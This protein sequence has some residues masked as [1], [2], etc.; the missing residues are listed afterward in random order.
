MVR[1]ETM[2]RENERV[3]G[4]GEPRRGE[5]R[6]MM[7]MKKMGR[8]KWRMIR[9]GGRGE[10]GRMTKRGGRAEGVAEE[11]EGGQ[12]GGGGGGGEV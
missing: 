9:G 3:G 8:G 5:K 2:I 1:R 12:R 11:G 6:M 10:A 4:R 7:M